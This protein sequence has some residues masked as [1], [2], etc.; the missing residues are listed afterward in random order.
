[1]KFLVDAQLPR[2]L[3]VWLN[4]A[5][6]LAVHTLELSEGNRTSDMQVV[7]YADQEKSVVISKDADFVNSHLLQGRPDQFLLISAGNISNRDLE[8]LFM[9]LLP[10]IVSAFES[11]H[12]LELGIEGLVI[13]G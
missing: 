8:R 4:N 11:S 12:F 1:M 7:D 5:G 10:E 13:R 3:A 9:P 6:H 2:R